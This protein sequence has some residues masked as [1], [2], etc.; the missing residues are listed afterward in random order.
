MLVKTADDHT[1]ISHDMVG[2]VR[3]VMGSRRAAHIGSWSRLPLGCKVAAA[4]QRTQSMCTLAY[5]VAHGGST[6]C[7]SGTLL[8]RVH[9]QRSS[10]PT[11]TTSTTV[12]SETFSD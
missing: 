2:V 3:W 11:C 12:P 6:S 4:S 10:R 8:P 7:S 1:R 9:R 5:L